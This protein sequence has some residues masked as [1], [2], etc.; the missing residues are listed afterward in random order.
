MLYN[1]L[2]VFAID[3]YELTTGSTSFGC[4]DS[5]IVL[6]LD[7]YF[8]YGNV[9]VKCY[10]LKSSHPHLFPLSPKVCFLHLCL[11]C[12][13]A[14]RI[15]GTIFLNF[16][17]NICVSIY[18]ICLSLSELFHSVYQAPV[19]ST[20][21]NWLKCVP[22]YNWVIFHSVYVSQFPYPFIFQWTSRL[23]PCPSYCK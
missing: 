19:Y 9:H 13:P 12:Y 18:S 16:I 7:I 8:T 11:L 23:L 10:P 21:Y 15:N 1:I 5:F 22:F 4:P 17:Y 6:V 2:I 20:H 3:Q 14:C